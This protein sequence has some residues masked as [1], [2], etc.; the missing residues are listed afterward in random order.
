MLKAFIIRL[1]EAHYEVVLKQEFATYM[2]YTWLIQAK[3][4]VNEI[5][6]LH[7]RRHIFSH[8]DFMQYCD[9]FTFLDLFISFTYSLHILLY[10]VYSIFSKMFIL[11][12]YESW[13]LIITKYWIIRNNEYLIMKAKLALLRRNELNK[14]Q[15]DMK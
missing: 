5:D 1:P 10:V 14:T 3:E 11:L 4:N 7:I 6:I 13:N 12:L 15:L 2:S 8:I 9:R